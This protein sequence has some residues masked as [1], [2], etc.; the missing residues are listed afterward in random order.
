MLIKKFE[1]FNNKKVL[2][3]HGLEGAPSIEKTEIFE[4]RGYDVIFPHIDY[5]TEYKK[6]R[7]RSK[8]NEL[9]DISKN[10]DLIV[11]QS[12]GGYTA[13][14]L[15][16]ILNINTILINPALDREKTKLIIKEFNIDQDIKYNNPNIEIYFG[17]LDDL[18][19]MDITLN[20][21]KKNNIKYD[22]HIITDMAHRSST[23]KI[24]EIL[25]IS[26]FIN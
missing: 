25:E 1:S 18:V 21:I 22:I 10:T 2:I 23:E 16:N 26:K 24:D 19:P 15:S 6:D 3:L 7:F 12:L 4:K 20:Y 5:L 14:L 13:F 9:L 8:F 17:K 11:G